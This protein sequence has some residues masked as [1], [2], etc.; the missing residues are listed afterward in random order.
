MLLFGCDIDEMLCMVDVLQFFEEYGEV[1]LVG[2]NKGKLGMMVIME[3]VV[4]YLVK[5]VKKL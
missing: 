4:V 5:N 1:C 2:W 3:G